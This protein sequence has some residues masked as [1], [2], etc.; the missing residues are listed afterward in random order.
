MR[1]KWNTLK[2]IENVIVVLKSEDEMNNKRLIDADLLAHSVRKWSFIAKGQIQYIEEPCLLCKT[3]E[4]KC[5]GCPVF[6]VTGSPHCFKTS[7][8]HVWEKYKENDEELDVE[9]QIWAEEYL[10]LLEKLWR[11]RKNRWG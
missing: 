1:E 8:Y 7:F 6:E 5:A 11:D 4:D 2:D 3:Y 9:G 10:N